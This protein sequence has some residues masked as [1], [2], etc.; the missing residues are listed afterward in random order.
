[1]KKIRLR[2]I[3]EILSEHLV[4]VGDKIIKTSN[5]VTNL[6]DELEVEYELDKKDY[7]NLIDALNK[8]LERK[9]KMA[10]EI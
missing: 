5:S 1:M 9:K 10:K 6:P 3:D 4:R 2:D 7:D 8:S